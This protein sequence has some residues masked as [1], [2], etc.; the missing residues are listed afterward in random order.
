MTNHENKNHGKD[1]DGHASHSSG[2]HDAD[3][4]RKPNHWIGTAIFLALVLFALLK[5]SQ[6]SEAFM[7]FCNNFLR[8][9]NDDVNMIPVGVVLYF[10]FWFI[11][12]K[13]LMQPHIALVEKREQLTSGSEQ[14]AKEI[15]KN[16]AIKEEQYAAKIASARAEAS[17]GNKQKIDEVRKQISEELSVLNK[18]VDQQ[19][20]GELE[21]LKGSQAEIR[22]RLFAN[23]STLV[24]EL[25][26]KIQTAGIRN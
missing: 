25:V 20:A 1:T 22:E 5:I 12:D 13:F 24:D 19:V 2:H 18:E 14:G 17:S 11:A 23:A 7:A 9:T 6:N 26:N 3:H 8:L 4:H 15:L 21:K 16:I 10:T